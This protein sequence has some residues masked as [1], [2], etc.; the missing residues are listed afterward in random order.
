MLVGVLMYKTF[1]THASECNVRII[2]DVLISVCLRPFSVQFTI[3][4]QKYGYSSHSCVSIS[5]PSVVYFTTLS[6]RS[7]LLYKTQ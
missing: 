2:K 5:A 6:R 1:Q 4:L 7:E 3:S